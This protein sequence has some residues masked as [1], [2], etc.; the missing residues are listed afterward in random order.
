MDLRCSENVFSS[1]RYNCV[2][3][4]S[5]SETLNTHSEVWKQGTI[6]VGSVIF[7]AV[8]VIAC[9]LCSLV[10]LPFYLQSL[11]MPPEEHC[12]AWSDRNKNI[13]QRKQLQFS[14]LCCICNMNKDIHRQIEKESTQILLPYH[15]L[16]ISNWRWMSVIGEFTHLS[17]VQ[18]GMP[19]FYY[20]LSA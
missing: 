16:D 5:S 17:L 14:I 20:N 3:C 12:C 9:L 4:S 19:E 11:G 18:E 1:L 13:F 2:D 15:R 6:A 8:M 7:Q 10:L